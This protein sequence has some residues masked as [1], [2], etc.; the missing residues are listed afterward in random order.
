MGDIEAELWIP[1]DVSDIISAG[2]TGL[3]GLLADG[4]VLKFPRN[5]N[6]PY[7]IEH[8]ECEACILSALGKHPRITKYLGKEKYGLRF[9][10]AVYGDVR[11]YMTSVPSK[12]ISTQLRLK[13]SI[14]GAE[15]LAF[16]HSQGV[17]HCD[18]NPNNFLLYDALDLRLCDFSESMYGDLEAKVME[19]IRYFL[20]RE[21]CST[22][23]VQTDLFAFGSV[24]YYFMT[25]HEPYESL[26]EDQ[27]TAQFS[28]EIFP[29]VDTILGGSVILGCWKKRFKNADQ[30]FQALTKL[31]KVLPPC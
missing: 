5:K 26:S 2:N 31:G 22:P 15:A 4:T 9:E 20:P 12:N 6:Y 19:S 18:L 8:I 24:V 14:Q 28:R 29:N 23:T 17:I 16:I 21:E 11:S 7:N 1:P 10:R 13:W 30:V 25:G 3:F 27:V